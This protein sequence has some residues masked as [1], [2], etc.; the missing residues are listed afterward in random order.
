MSRSIWRALALVLGAAAALAAAPDV[1]GTSAHA[2]T[3]PRQVLRGLDYI[4]AQQRTDAGFGTAANTSWAI[5][6]AA[7]SGER[8]TTDT[9]K[10]GAGTPFTNLDG[11]NHEVAATGYDEDNAAE[12]YARTILAYVAAGQKVRVF[13]A[14]QPRVDLLAKLYGHQ[15]DTEGPTK[16]SFSPSA[17]SRDFQSIRTTAWAI[18]AMHTVGEDRKARFKDA[19]TWLSGQQRPDGGFAI[20]SN[21]DAASNAQ[22]TAMTVQALSLAPAE[23]GVDPAILRSARAYLKSQQRGDGG[24]PAKAGGETDAQAT[25]AAI[26]AIV[27]LGERQGDGYWKADGNTPESALTRLQLKTGAFA[28]KKGSSDQRFITTA[29]A[30]VALNNRSFSAFP[31]EL[32]TTVK[33]FD[34]RPQ[35]GSLSPKANAR[36]TQTRI[37]LIDASYTDGKN[38][39]GIDTATCRVFVNGANRTKKAQIGPYGLR[40]RLEGLANGPYNYRIEIADH[41]GNVRVVQRKF[42]VAVATPSGIGAGGSSGYIAPGP[43]S[44][45][46]GSPGYGSG[47]TITPPRA[48]APVTTLTPR[49]Y[50]SPSSGGSPVTGRTVVTPSPEASG[51]ASAGSRDDSAGYLGGSL[52]A[53]LPA[54]AILGY[55]LHRRRLDQLIGAS[56]GRLLPSR[57]SGWHQITS[58]LGVRKGPPSQG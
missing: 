58:A 37:V 43:S 48:P 40:L 32:G 18:L 31:R 50:A 26:Q 7:A 45:G 29:Y 11:R 33:P 51:S 20:S 5:L 12:Y 47:T 52:L 39:T 35:I 49:P 54:G 22:D 56:E 28:R 14:G 3:R 10:V 23:A 57:G 19:V 41:A 4:H 2:Q 27:S 6:A 9:W 21:G 16:G 15:D 25:A 46:Y 36:F 34:F 13:V 1:F 38:G 55:L 42:T 8:I 17:S 44:P 53:M 24:F 30:V